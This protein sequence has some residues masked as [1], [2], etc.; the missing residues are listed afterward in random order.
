M[1]WAMILGSWLVNSFFVRFSIV[2]FRGLF[3]G[4]RSLDLKLLGLNEEVV[5]R[6]GIINF[7]SFFWFLFI[8]VVGGF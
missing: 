5:F 6:S 8:C 2:V 3:L 4:G 7:R 1:C